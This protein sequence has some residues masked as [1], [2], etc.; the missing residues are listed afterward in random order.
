MASCL[1]AVVLVLINGKRPGTVRSRHDKARCRGQLGPQA[2][3]PQKGE[4]LSVAGVVVS[5]F[6]LVHVFVALRVF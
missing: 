6:G 5:V 1:H 4:G 3:Q 2:Q